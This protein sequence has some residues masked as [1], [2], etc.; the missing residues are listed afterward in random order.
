MT[1]FL[2][3]KAKVN[4]MFAFEAVELVLTTLKIILRDDEGYDCDGYDRWGYNKS[5]LTCKGTSH[6]SINEYSDFIRQNL[7][8]MNP[9]QM[10]ECLK[11]FLL[12]GVNNE[13]IWYNTIFD[14]CYKEEN[15]YDSI[16]I[17]HIKNYSFT[18]T[19]GLLQ[20]AIVCRKSIN[21]IR[22]LLELYPPLDLYNTGLFSS[23]IRHSVEL[24]QLLLEQGFTVNKLVIHVLKNTQAHQLVIN[25][26]WAQNVDTII[27]VQRFYK[28]RLYRPCHVWKDGR[29]TMQRLFPR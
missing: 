20:I 19:Y 6:D 3:I 8:K 13:N 16:A 15:T 28:D 1:F 11:V 27:R 2:K 21:L 4:K 29:T 26:Y 18:T 9:D 7:F 14:I 5:N 22:S 24:T 23:S 12:K 10:I 17:W 25:A